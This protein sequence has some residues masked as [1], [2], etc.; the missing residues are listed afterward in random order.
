MLAA[1]QSPQPGPA[2]P[3]PATVLDPVSETAIGGLVTAE[4]SDGYVRFRDHSGLIWAVPKDLV[5]YEGGAA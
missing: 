4:L 2:D 1:E 5:R 3:V